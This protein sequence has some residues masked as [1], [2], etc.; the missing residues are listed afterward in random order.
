L[1]RPRGIYGGIHILI[2]LWDGPR[3]PIHAAMTVEGM[4]FET[5]RNETKT[6]CGAVRIRGNAMECSCKVQARQ[7]SLDLDMHVSSA[8]A[9]TFMDIGSKT[10][11]RIS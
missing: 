2:G 10:P 3:D 11:S 6:E 5:K 8:S 1:K 4:E 7:V 9:P